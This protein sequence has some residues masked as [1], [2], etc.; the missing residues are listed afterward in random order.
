MGTQS[1]PP[2]VDALPAN[3]KP[4]M[5]LLPK[6][7]AVTLPPIDSTEQE[8]LDAIARV[9]F[10]TPDA[11]WTWY[12]SEFDGEDSFFGFVSGDEPELGYFSLA[13]LRE[14]RGKL[15]LPVERDRSFKPTPLREI[16]LDHGVSWA[17]EKPAA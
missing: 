2:Q 8:G 6:E 17:A 11:H 9:K 12:A 15:G 10:F 1:F 14:L 13:E 4:S 3:H 7:I 5:E 16:M